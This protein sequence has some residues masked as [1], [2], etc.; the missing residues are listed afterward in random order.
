MLLLHDKLITQ[1]EKRETSTTTCNETT[2]RDKLRVFVSRISPPSEYE[3]RQILNMPAN[4]CV[5]NYGEFSKVFR[6]SQLWNG[7][8]RITSQS[9]FSKIDQAIVS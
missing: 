7:L 5:P 2:L 3:G 4:C 8:L 1:G 9:I 6:G